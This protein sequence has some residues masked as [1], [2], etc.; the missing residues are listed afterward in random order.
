DGKGM[1]TGKEHGVLLIAQE[2]RK[3]GILKRLV[4]EVDPNAFVIITPV[5][6]ILGTGFRPLE[7]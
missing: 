5:E 6:D 3:M 1:Y 4:N 2:A 7:A